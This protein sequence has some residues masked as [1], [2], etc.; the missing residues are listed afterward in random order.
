MKYLVF[1][2]R[3]EARKMQRAL[4]RLMEL[5]KKGVHFGGG[6]HVSMPESPAD[7]DARSIK[8]Y[9]T[10][11]VDFVRHPSDGRFAVRVTQ[12]LRDVWRDHKDRLTTAQRTW[13]QNRL[14]GEADLG[15]D[16]ETDDGEGSLE[17]R[18]NEEVRPE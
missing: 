7:P 15:D 13:V 2:D 1:A 3:A 9:T 18:E 12:E 14:V 6:R 4:M 17:V 16:W 11:H 8:G 10:R 5:P